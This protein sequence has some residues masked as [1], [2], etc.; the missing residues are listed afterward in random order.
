MLIVVAALTA[1]A[2]RD[3]WTIDPDAAA[4]V[5]LARALDAGDGYVLDG[6][7]H[8]KYPPGLPVLL[9]GLARA[10]GPDGYAT[11]HLGLVAALLA[12]VAASYA[13]ARRLGYDELVALAVAAAVGSSQT[14]FDLSVRYLRTE[15]LFLAVS[16][17]A[18]L[19]IA[20]AL[21]SGGRATH[22]ALA[23]VLVAAAMLTRLAGVTLL[24]V[25]ALHLLRPA[26]P[27]GGRWRALVL[28]V[29]GLVVLAV[30]V[31]RGQQ[32]RAE[33][34]DA[35]D[36][37]AELM[38]AA[39]RDLTKTVPVD[40]PTLDAAG[41]VRR[42]T[43]N[44]VVFSRACGVLLT[45]V[46]RSGQVLP[47]GAGLVVL[48]LMG[49][50][51]A[52]RAAGGSEPWDRP[53][54]DAAVYVLGTLSLYLVWPF[55]QQERFYAPLLPWLLLAAGE[56]ALRVWR[57]AAALTHR[58][59]GR[60]LIVL[61]LA[62]VT[63]ALA[64]RHSDDPVVL[65]RWSGTYAAVVAALGATTIAAAIMLTRHALPG[66]KRL[67]VWLCP[68]VFA[69][70]WLAGRFGEWPTQVRAFEARRLAHPAPAPL[71]RI[72]VN[73][74]LEQ[75]AEYLATHAPAD[76][77]LMTDV[78]K[79]MTSLTGLRCVPFR[80]RVAPPAVLAEGVDYI[81]YTREI[82]ELAQ[83]MD[84]CAPQFHEALRFTPV[85]DGVREVVPVLYATRQPPGG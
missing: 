69:G 46:D 52:L 13:L 19:A 40:L 18:L 65:D 38:A 9:A 10:A 22:V 47:V 53:R 75:L 72:D 62:A 64:S 34:P 57:L 59:L 74:V 82:P 56:G 24:A 45:N 15:V 76:A 31:G 16:L 26:D 73:P 28:V 48:V 78:P 50:F 5:G 66:P 1:T 39:P 81:F 55:N 63:L 12:A 70:P 20:R 36:Y 14:L 43:G 60:W 85:F 35:P 71:D 42:V 30:W 49:L 27:R 37:G 83:V 2:V 80:Y 29:A 79:I 7:P 17:L 25:P 54:A 3:V 23:A 68:L 61:G 77:V 4:Y 11:F 32:I 51:A 33:F 41:L 44:L 8:A 84:A 21:A 58:P 6:V 67:A